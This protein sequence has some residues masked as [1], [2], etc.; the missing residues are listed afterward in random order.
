[1]P[2]ASSA[3]EAWLMVFQSDFEPMMIATSGVAGG[4]DMGG[5]VA[6]RLG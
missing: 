6:E 2:S 3:W 1:M 5:I 4:P